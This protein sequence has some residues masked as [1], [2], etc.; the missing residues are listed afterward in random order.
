LQQKLDEKGALDIAAILRIGMQTAAGLAAA[1]AQGLIHRDVKPANILLENGVE[2]V[3]ITDF[4]L[5]RAA[6]DASV[7]QSGLIAGTPQYMSPEQAQGDTIDYRSDLF[8]LGSVLYAM[9]TGRSPFR[10]GSTVAVLRSLVDEKPEPIRNVN[11]DI[12]SRLVATIDR[13]LAKRPDD[14]LQSAVEVAELL[15]LELSRLQQP[16]E[17]TAVAAPLRRGL[18]RTVAAAAALG[19]AIS[20]GLALSEMLGVTQ[21]AA[22]AF[23]TRTLDNAPDS[24]HQRRCRWML[25]SPLSFWRAIPPRSISSRRWPGPSRRQITETRSRFAAMG[26]SSAM[27][28]GSTANR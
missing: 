25:S 28:S 10:G 12:P 13:L 14:R 16:S 3:K 8:S 7:T 26:R 27:P 17:R 23:R 24:H 6:G 22:T 4:G 9:C 19:L 21:F 18:G 20:A 15:G 1:H 11:P 2:R 5:A